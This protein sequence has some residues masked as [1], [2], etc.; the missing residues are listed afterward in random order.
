MIFNIIASFD[1]VNV[2]LSLLYLFI[3]I[4]LHTFYFI[5]LYKIITKLG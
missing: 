2:F 3:Y 4:H 1:I 5:Y